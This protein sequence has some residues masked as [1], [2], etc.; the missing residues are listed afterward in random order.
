MSQIM[1]N[2]E[3]KFQ[4]MQSTTT[5]EGP[6][7]NVVIDNGVLNMKVSKFQTGKDG[8]AEPLDV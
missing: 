7:H 5:Y 3:V 4:L 6:F 1:N 8:P 2:L